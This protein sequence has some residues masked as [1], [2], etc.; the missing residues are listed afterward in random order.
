LRINFSNIYT[1][2]KVLSQIDS[3]NTKPDLFIHTILL[4]LAKY[5]KNQNKLNTLSLIINM[6]HRTY[7]EV[8]LIVRWITICHSQ[9]RT[10][11]VL[12]KCIA[13]YSWNRHTKDYLSFI[14]ISHQQM[15]FTLQMW[16][17]WFHNSL[18]CLSY[19]I[20]RFPW[21]Y[22][23]THWTKSEWPSYWVADTEIVG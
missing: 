17:F 1:N 10:E 16:L 8:E 6:G 3:A 19:T 14:V 15:A 23:V 2:S 7:Q 22:S 18:M 21:T 11:A 4:P 12:G 20:S 5:T 9:E 13:L